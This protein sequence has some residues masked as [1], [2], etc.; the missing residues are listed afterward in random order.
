MKKQKDRAKKKKQ[1]EL[2]NKELKKVSGG[3]DIQDVIDKYKKQGG[4]LP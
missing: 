3:I 1:A 2:S 4:G